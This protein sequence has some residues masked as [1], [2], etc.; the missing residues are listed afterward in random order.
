[1][2]PILKFFYYFFC[3]SNFVLFKAVFYFIYIFA[4]HHQPSQYCHNAICHALY[5]AVRTW[6]KKNY[7]QFFHPWNIQ[8]SADIISSA[9][10]TEGDLRVEKVQVLIILKL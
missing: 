8:L 9:C 4:Q 10:V 2:I 5:P 3:S 6:K 7:F 1:L